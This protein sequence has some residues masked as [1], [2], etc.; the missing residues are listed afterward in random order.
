MSRWR[1]FRVVVSHEWR[2]L[3]SERT[4]WPSLTLL[5]VM[6][7]LGLA[8]GRSWVAFQEQT[9]SEARLEETRRLDRIRQQ[10]AAPDAIKTPA[11]EDP[12][13]PATFGNTLGVRTAVMPPA[14]LGVLSVGQSDLYPH[15]FKVSTRGRDT[16]INN[17]E[18]ENP[19]NLLAG[20]FDAAFVIVY[21]FPLLILGLS[22]HLLAGE[23]EQGTLAMVMAQPVTLA[24]LAFG[25]IVARAAVVLGCAVVFSLA[26][27]LVV[28]ATSAASGAIPRLLAWCLLVVAYG[29]FWFSLAVAVNALGLNSS[30]SAVALA[31]AWI[32]FV[33]VAPSAMNVA[34]QSMYPVPSRVE[35]VQTMRDASRDATAQGSRLLAR[36]F[37]D[38]PEM[39]PGGANKEDFARFDATAYAVQDEIARRVQPVIDDFDD[40]L[41]RQQALVDRLRFLSPA[42][43]VYEALNDVAGTSMSRY[44]H[45]LTQVNAFHQDW[46]QYF[47][48]RALAKASMSVEA[49]DTMPAF[50]FVEEPLAQTLAK[51]GWGFVGLLIPCL[52]ATALSASW[53]RRYEVA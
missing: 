30:T 29:A 21:L 16:F 6:L 14:P 22:Y 44:R 12:R 23:R 51:A 25:K 20:R 49:M 18:I 24:S 53:L 36:Y 39:M 40:R 45:F 1:L 28:P 27:A 26:G 17:D 43:V 5:A 2:T 35:M 11:A 15:Y 42:V 4:L 33:V 52:I 3:G 46:Q 32:L 19:L 10:L 7:T 34:A 48:P 38:H 50:E 8:N 31:F 37:E 13:S 41:A 47:I 9:L